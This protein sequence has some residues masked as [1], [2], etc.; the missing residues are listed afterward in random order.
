MARMMT[1]GEILVEIMATQRGQSFRPAGIIGC[2]GDDNFGWLNHRPPA[3]GRCRHECHC[4]APR[5]GHR[6][7]VCHLSPGE[8]APTRPIDSTFS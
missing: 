3:P 6:K 2:V 7:R 5:R 8:N 4:A 1:I